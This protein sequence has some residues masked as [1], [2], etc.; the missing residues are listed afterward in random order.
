MMNT[1]RHF[2]DIDPNYF[3][4]VNDS[5]IKS[6]PQMWKTYY[7]H[8]TFIKLLK[9]TVSVLR[10]EQKLSIWVEGAYG[11]GKSHAVLTLKKLLDAK[12]ED[13]R[14]YFEKYQ[15]SNDLFNKLQGVKNE[16]KILTVHRYGS[17][18]IRNDSN[19]AFAIEESIE[20]AL[21]D[22]GIENSGRK[23]LKYGIIKWLSNPTN[24]GF[25]D[26]KIKENYSN[27]FA[28]DNSDDILEKL[29]NYQDESLSSLM[30]KIFT[31]ADECGIK[32]MQLSIDDL[33]GWIKEIIKENNLKA[34][35]FIWDEFTEF[36]EK[37]TNSLTGFQQITELSS[38]IPFYLVIVTHKSGGLFNDADKDKNKILD[39]F[40]K[41]TCVIDLPENMA[42]RLIG[43]AMVKKDDERVRNEWKDLVEYLYD[44]TRNSRE[45]IKKKAKIGDEELEDIL[46]IH[47]YTALLLK[48]I[49]SAFESNQR[50]MFDFIKNDKGD[51]VKG[52]QY[53][54]D[55][56]GPDQA[57]YSLL[58]LDMLWDFFYENG[59]ENLSSDIRSILDS[60]SFQR[61]RRLTQEEDRVLKAILLL[62]AISHKVGDNVELF[63]PNNENLENAFE[64]SDLNNVS[65]CAE[66]LV[67][68]QILYKKPLG[69][70]KF[71]YSALLNSIDT[72][73]I[74]KIK[75]QFKNIK[76]ETLV[77]EGEVGNFLDLDLSLP[78]LSL[79]YIIENVS[80]SSFDS[81]YRKM[82][83][84]ASKLPNHIF[85]IISFAKDDSEAV[86][87]R[88]K[89]KDAINEGDCN[90]IFID[91]SCT[92]LGQENIEQYCVNMANCRY[93]LVKDRTLSKQY[94]S[95][96]KHILERWKDRIARGEFTVY[97]KYSI[98]GNRVSSLDYLKSILKDIDDKRYLYS[99][100]SF[101]TTV[102][103]TM[104]MNN[105]ISKGIECGIGQKLSGTYKS[106]NEAT[107]LEKYL[108]KVWEYN[109]KYWEDFPLLIISKI[110]SRVEDIIHSSFEKEDGRVSIDDIY[111]QLK[112]PPFGFLTCNLTAFVFGFILKEYA[113]GQYK[114]TDGVTSGVLNS[115]K[116]KELIDECLKK[117][118][119]SNNRFKEQYIVSVTKEE[120][121][122]NDT[123][124]R[125]FNISPNHCSSIDNTRELIRQKMK[126]FGFPLWTIKYVLDKEETKT[127]D[128]KV[129]KDV[130]DLYC[131]IANDNNFGIKRNDTANALEIGKICSFNNSV[132]DD[133]G[134]VFNRDKCTLGMKEYLKHY[135]DGELEKL[136][137][138]VGD[139]GQYI[140][141]LRAKFDRV[142]AA[143]WV[144]NVETVNE[145][146]DEVIIEYK[147]I[148]ESNKIFSESTNFNSCVREWCDKC[149]NIKIAYS[150]VRNV[151]DENINKFL[152]LLVRIVKAENIQ[153]NYIA[154]FYNELEKNKEI[155]L[156]FYNKQIDIFKKGLSFYLRGLSDEEIV[157]VYNLLPPSFTKE[158]SEYNTLVEDLVKDYKQKSQS[159]KLK[160]LW[161]ERTNT[162]SPKDWSNRY[163]MP[164]LCMVDECDFDQA[165]ESFD[166]INKNI[167]DD[168]SLKRAYEYL[169]T[170]SVFNKLKNEEI[171]NKAFSDKFV[172]NYEVLF[173]DISEVKEYLSEMVVAE[174]YDWLASPEV[175]RKLREMAE[176]KYN[177]RGCVEATSI[178]ENMA[179]ADVKKYLKDL[180]KDNMIVGMAI[181]KERK[182]D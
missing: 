82:R 29:K 163:Q 32:V 159:R 130:I 132:V 53:F 168:I 63:I 151:V 67:R 37:N 69:L 120:T 88:K 175:E 86:V 25:F 127:K 125:I 164:I 72:I 80:I 153:D 75:E 10:R 2:F 1:Y 87:L 96:S 150:S 124:S 30:E 61:V 84:E 158:A 3:P 91:T 129:L 5:V 70:D 97:S 144:W 77:H 43:A 27:L 146:I 16:G 140:N 135:K 62:D 156:N 93:Y 102:A 44:S 13:A 141:E 113:F 143:N 19:L 38:T 167:C 182:G 181:I 74:E 11:T 116:L 20:K 59:K 145:K 165:K 103:K 169:S 137:I 57:Q 105:Y 50:S 119:V 39:R 142:D 101:F 40:I 172:K 73:E 161:K 149:K 83:D 54:I 71:K 160:A 48:H 58:T 148:Q 155:F 106:N 154:L 26:A 24:K 171:R 56:Y 110:K 45:V 9:D 99:L 79:R 46:P 17:S 104:Y 28:G 115:D 166:V 85:A 147:I 122:F 65:G 49:S 55:N 8:E 100:E 12:E 111:N 179:L 31:L 131:G 95:N 177:Q 173:E 134:K 170:S 35:V 139:F 18:S 51:D 98:E 89:I 94:E 152:D 52:F 180:I 47:P 108:E 78:S 33:I 174:P 157:E 64:G 121:V 114:W 117:D 92:P 81:T 15:L 41:P 107:K 22:S 36:F 6:N 23:A 21:E 176:A 76:T 126:T 178:I 68:D 138:N 7:P 34:I 60:Y 128:K 118:L 90:T 4:V 14:S 42:F 133:L 162:N 112:Q 66:K 136:A 109:G 123:T